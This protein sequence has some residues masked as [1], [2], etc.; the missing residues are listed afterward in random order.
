MCSAGV[1]LP[2]SLIRPSR[3]HCLSQEIK[4]TQISKVPFDFFWCCWVC[5]PSRGDRYHLASDSTTAVTLSLSPW[6]DA[7]FLL[8][9]DAI[10][11]CN[12]NME[13]PSISLVDFKSSGHHFWTLLCLWCLVF[14]PLHATWTF[15]F[16]TF[17]EKADIFT[18]DSVTMLRAIGKPFM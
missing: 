3:F 8:H 13:L 12:S 2:K 6:S 10:A 4:E 16:T 17:K 18:A 9:S 11:G 14:W 7:R 15:T 5:R 1:F